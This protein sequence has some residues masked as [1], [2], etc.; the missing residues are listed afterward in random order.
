R[1]FRARREVVVRFV[2]GLGS[3]EGDRLAFLRQAIRILSFETP[4]LRV[5]R[6]SPL[7]ESQAM[8]P[9]DAPA[10]GSWDLPFLNLSLECESSLSPAELLRSL[11]AC[12]VRL[13]RE[14]RS[15]W[16][17][18]RIDIDIL[19]SDGPPVSEPGLLVPHPGLE[20]RP[21]ALLPLADLWPSYAKQATQWR[22]SAP[23]HVPF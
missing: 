13:G 23:D 11:K 2:L 18:R 5:L 4:G 21:F 6:A 8:L 12:E 19:A 9:P 17:P 15:R 1:E 14:S 7:Y 10:D 22:T 20:T 16:A 3:N